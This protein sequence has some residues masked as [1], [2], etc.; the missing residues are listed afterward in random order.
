MSLP[1]LQSHSPHTPSSAQAVVVKLVAWLV[2]S[3]QPTCHRSEKVD[4]AVQVVKG[5]PP[6]GPD[7]IFER[8]RQAGAEDGAFQVGLQLQA[9]SLPLPHRP[10][11]SE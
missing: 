8:A 2:P 1:L 7:D 5:G 6:K 9:S 3:L 4:F 10:P 11:Q